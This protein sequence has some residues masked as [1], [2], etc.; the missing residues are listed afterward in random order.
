MLLHSKTL[1]HLYPEQTWLHS[2]EE[3]GKFEDETASSPKFCK[4]RH[5]IYKLR[6]LE[7]ECAGETEGP[8]GQLLH[9]LTG[10]KAA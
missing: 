9:F 2:L 6:Q 4:P 8:I 5:N 7:I 10:R 1:Y 3:S